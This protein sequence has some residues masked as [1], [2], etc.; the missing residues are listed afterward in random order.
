MTVKY[1]MFNG[2]KN[3]IESKEFH[4]S[5][6]YRMK[7]ITAPTGFGKSYVMRKNLV[8]FLMNERGVQVLFVSYPD[9][10]IFTSFEKKDM[11]RSSGA[12]LCQKMSE[13]IEYL[14]EDEDTKIIYGSQLI[15]AK[16]Y[17]A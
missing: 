16:L 4:Y 15:I 6:K 12:I 9:T 1:D 2:I 8:P 10:A 14:E 11:A 7:L 3:F 17:Y 5:V 13:V